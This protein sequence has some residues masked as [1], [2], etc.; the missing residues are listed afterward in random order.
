MTFSRN[1]ADLGGR[2]LRGAAFLAGARLFVRFFSLINLVILARLLTPD[3]FG[4]ATLAV[5]ALGFLQAFS[6][7]K[8]NNALIAFDDLGQRHLDTA[9]TIGFIRGLLIAGLLFAGAGAIA[10]FMNVPALESVLQVMSAVLLIDGLKNPAFLIYERNVDFSKEFRRQTVATLVASLSGIAAAFYFR[11]YWAIVIASIVERVLQLVLSYWRIPYRPRFGL[12]AWASF[13]SFSSWLTFQGMLSQLS[14]MASRVL[15]GKYLDAG[16]V[17]VF[18]AARLLA[19][20]PTHELM[21]PLRRVLFPAL[22]SIKHDSP[23]LRVAYRNAQAT[24]FGLSLPISLGMTF[25]AR[26]IILVLFGPKWLAAAIPLQILAPA[27]AIGTL[28]AATNSLAMALGHVRGLFLRSAI[29]LAIAY[30]AIYVGIKL[31]GL[32]G[33]AFGV[34]AY[35]LA[36]TAINLVFVARMVGDSPLAPLSTGYRSVVSAASML[37]VLALVSPPFDA[38]RSAAAQL[39]LLVP[40]VGLGAGIYGALHYGLW[41]LSGRPPGFEENLLHYASR[42]VRRRSPARRR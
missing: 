18:A 27:L 4:I 10:R 3:D 9:F 1:E 19:A 25:Y 29:V 24:I 8:L 40:L 16:A 21:A 7:V 41:R 17:G 26:E 11:S 35:L 22:S 42:V 15:I 38:S 20:L 5:T 31:G 30:P 23:R 13:I 2:V 28:G 33:A 6:D 14:A 32:T 37:G 36:G 34:A 12:A 39:A